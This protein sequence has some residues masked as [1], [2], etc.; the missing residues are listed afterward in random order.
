MEKIK[1]P[2]EFLLENGLI[3]EFNRKILHPVG[4]ALE[5]DIRE[6]DEGRSEPFLQLWK[7]PGYDQEGFLYPPDSYDVG[8]SK[9]EKF[10]NNTGESRIEKR[11][12]KLGYIVQG[13]IKKD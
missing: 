9:L 3:F 5:V 2:V 6:N 10:M 4:L 12:E 1:D 8:K 13:D 7:C 11:L